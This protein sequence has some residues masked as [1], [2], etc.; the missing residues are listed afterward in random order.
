MLQRRRD[1]WWWTWEDDGNDS[2]ENRASGR[3]TTRQSIEMTETSLAVDD[4]GDAV[5]RQLKGDTTGK[6]GVRD[7]R[8]RDVVITD[9]DEEETT[10]SIVLDIFATERGAAQCGPLAR[11]SMNLMNDIPNHHQQQQQQERRRQRHRSDDKLD[12]LECALSTNHHRVH[13][14]TESVMRRLLSLTE[15]SSN[16]GIAFVLQTPRSLPPSALQYVGRDRSTAKIEAE[17]EVFRHN[18]DIYNRNV[19]RKEEEKEH[20]AIIDGENT[21][22]LERSADEHSN[23]DRRILI[24]DG[25]SD[26][27]NMG[28][29]IRSAFL[30]GWDAIYTVVNDANTVA[31]SEMDALGLLH[32]ESSSHGRVSRSDKESGARRC[33]QLNT[34]DAYSDKVIRASS[35]SCFDLPILSGT[36]EEL[37]DELY[38]S[39]TK[40]NC[41]TGRV[42][43]WF[44]VLGSVEMS[45]RTVVQIDEIDLHIAETAYGDDEDNGRSIALVLGK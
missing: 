22:L 8:K 23:V 36:A 12:T 40:V 15:S 19:G 11:R 32:T 44:T 17:Q 41:S 13:F 35:G 1:K 42:E 33:P 31:D 28:S 4:G 14:C 5:L 39:E 20:N 43:R 30:L 45:D 6:V 37:L 25:V 26:P 21:I 16:E 34:S 18:L 38:T 29:L 3:G 24:L 27:G 7:Y 10:G 2:K 9:T